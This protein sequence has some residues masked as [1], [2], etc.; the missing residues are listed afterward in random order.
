MLSIGLAAFGA[1]FLFVALKA[2]QQLNVVQT[3]YWWVMP[4]SL[5]MAACEAYLIVNIVERGWGWI[6]LP[7]GI[8]AGLGAMSAMWL[9]RKL[10]DRL[11]GGHV[12]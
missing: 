1:S 4:T 3:L 2:F 9:H 7:I 5:G 6:V 10:E 12:K 8:G 11:G